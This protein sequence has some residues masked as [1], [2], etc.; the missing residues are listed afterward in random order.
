MSKLM[1]LK[2]EG[3]GMSWLT[4]VTDSFFDWSSSGRK[5]GG[6]EDVRRAGALR[7]DTDHRPVGHAPDWS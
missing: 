6:S 4:V 7:G 5:A 3:G 1:L 2:K